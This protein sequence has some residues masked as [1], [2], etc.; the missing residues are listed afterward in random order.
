MKHR[1]LTVLAAVSLL[2]SI[3]CTT[4]K[5][6]FTDVTPTNVHYTAITYLQVNNVISGYTDGTFKPLQE[7][8]RAELLKIIIGGSKIP[9]DVSAPSGFSDIDESAWYAPYVRKAKQQG[10][11]KGYEDNTFKPA[12]NVSKSEAVKIIALANN[13]NIPS[14]I[15]SAPYTDTPLT[16]WFTPYISIAK[17]KNFLEEASR[18]YGP[19]SYMN[20]GQ[21]SEVLFRIMITS[22]NKA[23]SYNP[24]FS[25][26]LSLPEY[27][28]P[29]SLPSQNT[30]KELSPAELSQ[31]QYQE[32]PA[33]FFEGL[34]LNSTFPNTYYLNEVYYFEGKFTGSTPKQVFAF[35]APEG[36][37]D[38][39]KY[40]D[41]IGEING[42]TFKIPVI[43]RKSGNYRMGIIPGESGESKV[44]NIRVLEG[45]PSAGKT[46]NT[47]TVSTPQLSYQN[48]NSVVS[49]QANNNTLIKVNFIQGSRNQYFLFRQNSNNFKIPY[50]DL[51]GFQN[52]QTQL[53]IQAA[54][55]STSNPLQL[56]TGW[57]ISPAKT[58]SAT[59]HTYSEVDTNS[60]TVTSFPG[61]KSSP[62][63]ITFSG[64]AKKDIASDAYIIKPNGQV[65]SITLQSSLPLKDLTDGGTAVS[66]G[67]TFTFNY[68]P[69]S[70]GT[71]SLEIN[72]LSGLAVINIPVYI[73]NGYPLTPDYFDL[74]END[75][76]PDSY[77]LTDYRTQLLKLINDDRAKAQLSPVTLDL[78][79]NSLAQNH[80]QDMLTRNF[81]GHINPDGQ[82][83][84][85]RRLEANIPT[86]VGENLAN[87]QDIYFTHYG[88][89]QSAVHRKNIL[90]PLWTKVGIGMVKNTD[91]N[92]LTV[93]EFSSNPLTETD[94]NNIE[95]NLINS[96]NNTRLSRGISTLSK[97]VTLSDIAN[98]W[99]QIMANQQFFGFTAPNGQTL[100]ELINSINTQHSIQAVILEASLEEQL[101]SEINTNSQSLDPEWTKI[102][103]GIKTDKTGALKTTILYT[104]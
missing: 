3:N 98:N 7:V 69:S 40:V 73:G 54:Q 93:E 30:A 22:A 26:N 80:A 41:Y 81:F 59:T 87:A 47:N 60:I 62:Q 72:N 85:D 74:H 29:T 100:A 45:Y 96:L 82:T 99:S 104:D 24:V 36:E 56:S 77:N 6:F 95:N 65:D 94:L 18:F 33:S 71:Y 8:T 15:T 39:A 103:I 44:L 5:A 75:P 13:W 53:Y 14:S 70:I 1:K 52:T 67:S 66:A 92:F 84:D 48:F 51:S 16:A 20:R 17:S 19:Y 46:A 4:T 32:Q 61:L 12:Q 58:F 97:D 9:L 86:P 63:K 102:G 83:P 28:V 43:F 91:G 50:A 76:V 55:R 89:M 38:S 35:L 49:W 34:S 21:V 88:L 79:L 10:W 25:Q 90:D 101:T 42:N 31:I 68:T 78:P 64:T 37:T 27:T 23:T 57:S 2:F 11:I